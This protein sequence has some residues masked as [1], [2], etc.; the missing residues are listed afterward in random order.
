MVEVSEVPTPAACAAAGPVKALE[1]M[2]VVANAAVIGRKRRMSFAPR[3]VAGL[4][5]FTKRRNRLESHGSPEPFA[6]AA[7]D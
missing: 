2:T 3:A 6:L 4:M 5:D 1:A 7:G